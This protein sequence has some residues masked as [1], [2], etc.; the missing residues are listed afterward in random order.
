[1]SD[2]AHD[3]EMTPLARVASELHEVYTAYMDAGFS[4]QRA[5]ELTTTVL[6]DHLAS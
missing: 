3:F 4:E 6:M 1:M 5:F 2:G